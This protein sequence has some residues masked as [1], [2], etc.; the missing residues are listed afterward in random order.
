MTSFPRRCGEARPLSTPAAMAAGL[1]RWAMRSSLTHFSGARCGALARLAR[2]HPGGGLKSRAC[3]ALRRPDSAPLNIGAEAADFVPTEIASTS[4]ADSDEPHGGRGLSKRDGGGRRTVARSYVPRYR[5]GYRSQR[6]PP[7]QIASASAGSGR[8]RGNR[9]IGPAPGR[10]A[11]PDPAWGRRLAA[12]DD[13]LR[14]SNGRI[15]RWERNRPPEALG[16][17]ANRVHP[18]LA[19]CAAGSASSRFSPGSPRM[20]TPTPFA[21]ARRSRSKDRSRN[22]PIR[23]PPRVTRGPGR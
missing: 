9:P 3:S 18:I 19:P 14:L 13:H 5:R 22:R 16:R 4:P 20:V 8:T 21:P 15:C 7:C 2:D 10:R 1:P 23:A 12:T 11:S 6:N 17:V